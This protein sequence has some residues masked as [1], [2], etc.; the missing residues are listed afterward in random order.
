MDLSL[1]YRT[2]ASRISAAFTPSDVTSASVHRWLRKGQ[3]LFQEENSS[4]GSTPSS[5][6]DVVGR[7]E[8][9]L[10]G[11]AKRM[12]QSTTSLKPLAQADGSISFDGVD[13]YLEGDWSGLSTAGHIFVRVKINNDP[14]TSAPKAGLWLIHAATSTHTLHPH[15]D[16]LVYDITLSTARKEL[17]TTP[18]D[19]AVFHTWSVSS[20]AS[21]WICRYN[22]TIYHNTA[23]NTFDGPASTARIGASHAAV[24]FLDGY[25]LEVVLFD[26]VLSAADLTSM[27]DYMA[28]L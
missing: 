1:S 18:D 20:K 26:D 10:L 23:T 5:I 2:R 15:T 17:I 28:A 7:W 12:S 13:D 19:F 27:L 14:P 9:K 11:H 22:S 6:G 8:D 4:L 3:A 25:V 21:E 16:D 24:K